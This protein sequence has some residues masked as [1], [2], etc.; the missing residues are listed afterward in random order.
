MGRK[1]LVPGLFLLAVWIYQDGSVSRL[2]PFAEVRAAWHASDRLLL[3]RAGNTLHEMRV[4]HRGRRLAWVPLRDIS[5]AALEVL[6][7]AEDQRFF[8]HGG[9]DFLALG[10]GIRDWVT[11]GYRRGASTITMQLAGILDHNLSGRSRGRSLVRKWGQMRAAWGLE[12]NWSKNEIL[13]A[14]LNRVT[15][16]GELEGIG[17]AAR[18]L[19]DKGVAGLTRGDGVILAALLRAPNAGLEEVTARACR[20]AERVAPERTCPGLRAEIG[21]V[22]A[23]GRWIR[24]LRADAPQLA[25]RLLM[26]GTGDHVVTTLNAPL[27]RFVRGV[28]DAELV[29]LEGRN[30]HHGAALVLANDS[31]EVLAYV[32]NAPRAESASQVDGIQALRQAGSTLKPF[33]YGL[34]LEQRRLTAASLL[35]DAPLDIVTARGLYVPR[36]YEEHYKGWVTLRTALASSL[37]IPAV[38]TLLLTGLQ[39]MVVRLRDLGFAG[40]SEEGDFYGPALALGSVEVSLWQLVNAYRVLANGGIHT[41]SRVRLAERETEKKTVMAAEAAFIISDI[42]S[43]PSARALTFG[44]DSVLRLP[45]WSAV[46]TGTSKGMRDNWCVG[47]SSAWTVGVWVGNFDGEPMHDVSGISGA[48]PAWRAVMSHLGG[49]GGERP[50]PPGVVRTRTR[51]VG[52]EEGERDEWYLAGTEMD[53]VERVQHW[54]GRGRIAYPGSG[55]VIALD[56]DIPRHLERVFFRMD[57]PQE[58]YRWQLDGVDMARGVG[59]TPVKGHHRLALLNVRGEVMDESRFE[60]RG[61]DRN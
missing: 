31:G 41:P 1:L 32:G 21:E 24:P 30:V 11:K 7:A 18:G 40:V 8:S 2:P 52:A 15:F 49:G 61:N 58:G 19:F 56:P 17:S 47:F 26:D 20:L 23:R 54:E 9:V 22:L 43:D 33:L 12:R 51:F 34:A 3:D 53:R 45:F 28:L 14:Y 13:E 6:V 38:K 29:R 5:P 4:S 59:W 55:V 48:A 44:L 46:K 42:L 27:Q 37:N 10:A 35:E 39:P 57:P 25:R 16:R 36:N 50:V 60:V